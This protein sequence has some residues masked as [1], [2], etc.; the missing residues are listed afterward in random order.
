MS[1]SNCLDIDTVW[2]YDSHTD[3]Y[4]CNTCGLCY[5]RD[6]PPDPSNSF[7]TLAGVG[8]LL[9]RSDKQIITNSRFKNT[10]RRSAHLN[11]RFCSSLCKDP[12][13]PDAME[14]I[15]DRFLEFKE[16]DYFFRLRTENG[17][18]TKGD[19]K[20]ILRSLE[21]GKN[22]KQFKR[23]DKSKQE[24]WSSSWTTT[25]LERFKSI[26]VFL[27]GK[28]SYP[29][30]TYHNVGKVGTYLTKFSFLWDHWQP[31]ST[32]DSREN[33]KF[34]NR[35]HIP[36]LNFLFQRIHELLGP[37]Y[38]KYNRE[39]PI[40]SN[41]VAVKRLWAYW[42]EM[43][44]AANVPFRGKDDG[45]GFKETKFIQ[46]TLTNWIK[47]DESSNRYNCSQGGEGRRS[48]EADI[49]VDD[50]PG[51]EGTPTTGT[52]VI[53]LSPGGREG[54]NEEGCN[55]P[56]EQSNE[57]FGAFDYYVGQ[58]QPGTFST[59]EEL[60]GWGS[61]GIDLYNSLQ[62]TEWPSETLSEERSF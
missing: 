11:E 52:E 23:I 45:K 5:E 56:S 16:K 62:Y 44:K 53:G 20:K 34:K 9:C 6:L 32:R 61:T 40:P 37:E 10:Y 3:S 36:N 8:Q 46:P 21:K 12:I 38:S 42:R 49:F 14:T 35:K 27:T 4:T 29:M 48:D 15:R 18:C 26:G 24:Y 1:C 39:F 28:E 47:K 2:L 25:F 50:L 54:T 41:P 55:G 51:F 59:T 57:L 13:H 33:W 30:Y 22:K 58:L 60:Y 19:V 43:C 31:T 7:D 17:R